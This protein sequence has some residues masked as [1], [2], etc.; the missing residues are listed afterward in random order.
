MTAWIELRRSSNDVLEMTE[1]V[2]ECGFKVAMDSD[3][4]Y[5]DIGAVGALDQ[6]LHRLA[7]VLDDFFGLAPQEDFADGL[8]VGRGVH[9]VGKVPGRVEGLGEG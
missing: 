9:G 8:L 3:V 2:G 1:N 6:L 5:A 7:A 4:G